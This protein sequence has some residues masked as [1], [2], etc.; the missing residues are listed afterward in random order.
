MPGCL[1]LARTVGPWRITDPLVS[2]WHVGPSV[3]D[4]SIRI[5]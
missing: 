2:G 4:I 5:L 1:Q 3:Q